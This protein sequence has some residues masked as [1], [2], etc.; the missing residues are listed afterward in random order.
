M[1]ANH[2]CSIPPS[3]G[4]LSGGEPLRDFV[5]VSRFEFKNQVTISLQGFERLKISF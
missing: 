3:F 2:R 5:I 1:Y 4:R